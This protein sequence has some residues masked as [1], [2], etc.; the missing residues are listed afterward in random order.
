[1]SG[2]PFTEESC[3]KTEHCHAAIEPFHGRQSSI[4]PRATAGE[5]R[6]KGFV[7]FI[8]KL[9]VWH[10]VNKK[11]AQLMQAELSSGETALSGLGHEKLGE[12]NQNAGTGQSRQDHGKTFRCNSRSEQHE[13]HLEGC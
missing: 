1:M 8:N 5:P 11:R 6:T 12:K 9:L 13:I 10:A 7:G 4:V 3:C 2:D